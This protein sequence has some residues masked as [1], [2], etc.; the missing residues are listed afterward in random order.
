MEF[1]QGNGFTSTLSIS[2]IGNQAFDGTSQPRGLNAF[3]AVADLDFR[4]AVNL[5]AT[6]GTPLQR[7]RP[8]GQQLHHHVRP[9]RRRAADLPLR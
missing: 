7:L 5:E 4:Q 1:T 2:V 3:S 9:D 8:P 6:D